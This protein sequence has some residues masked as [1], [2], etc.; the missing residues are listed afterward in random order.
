MQ[1]DAPFVSEVMTVEPEWIDYNGHLNMAYYNVLFDRCVDQGFEML[2]LG[3]DYVKRT[4]ASFF[5]LEVHV[6]YLREIHEGDRVRSTLHL[7]DYDEKRTHFF[8]ELI[9]D[10]E[11]FVSA[12]SEQ[13]SMHVDMTA[14]KSAPFPAEVQERIRAMYEAHK[15]LPV[16]PQVGHVIAI[17]RK[18]AK[19]G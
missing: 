14:K 10:A 8:Q 18:S 5:T 4:N 3:P 11:G 9:H 17:P 6:T 1:F 13:M 15:E 7:L 19:V 2:G 12:T 16:N